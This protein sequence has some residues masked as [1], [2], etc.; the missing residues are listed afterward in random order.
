MEKKRIKRTPKSVGRTLKSYH[1]YLDEELVEFVERQEN[2]T[3]FFNAAIRTYI[4]YINYKNL[5]KQK[6]NGERL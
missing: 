6:D 2:K 4:R 3:R 5:I 1:L